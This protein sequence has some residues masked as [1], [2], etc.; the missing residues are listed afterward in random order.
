MNFKSRK[1]DRSNQPFRAPQPV[2]RNPQPVKSIKS[3]GSWEQKSKN[4]KNFYLLFSHRVTRIRNRESSTFFDS[5]AHIRPIIEA[6]CFTAENNEL[7]TTNYEQR[8]TNFWQLSTV[9]WPLSSD[10]W[11]L[12]SHLYTCRERFTNQPLFMQNK[13]NLV[14]R[15]RIANECK[16]I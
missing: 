3:A 4:L 11:P 15:R 2:T 7:W 1:L 16:S 10:L 12:S 13:P 8:T 5:N 14:R 9:L 6:R